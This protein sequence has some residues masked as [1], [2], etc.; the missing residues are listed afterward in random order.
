MSSTVGRVIV[1]AI[2]AE[3]VTHVFGVPGES[4]LPVLDA[5][6]DVPEVRIVPTRHEEGAGFMADAWARTT[7]R[8][9]VFMV[10]RGPGLA[11]AA[12]ALHAARQ[13]STPLVLLVGQVSRDDAGR[14]SFQ[15]L[16][17][18]AA[19][20]LLGK[21]GIEITEPD[22]AAEQ[23]QRAFYLARSGRPGPVVVSLPEDVGYA[24][25]QVTAVAR[26]TVP[27][28]AA[29]EEDLVRAVALLAG[30]GSV[31]LIVGTGGIAGAGGRAAVVALAERLG[32][33]V[34]NAWR[35]FDAFPNTHPQF[36]GNLPWLSAELVRPLRD[37]D[38]VLAIGTRL[39]DFTSMSYTVPS[40]KQKLIQIDVDAASMSVV[41]NP[42]VPIV[43]DAGSTVRRLA[44]LLESRT[45]ERRPAALAA[46][47]EAHDRYVASTAVPDDA[48]GDADLAVAIGQLR[49][50]LPA[51]AIVT[52]DAGAFAGYLNRYYRWTTPETFI[53]STS[54]PMGYAVP[55]AIGAKI[56]AP[57]RVVVGIAGDGG[58]AMTMSEIHTAVRLGLDRLVFVVFDNGVYG[59]IRN[60]QT[61]T[62]PGREIGV[63]LGSADLA[64]V[65]TGLGALGLSCRTNREFA[66]AL[67]KAIAADRPAVV[68][69]A[70]SPEQINA[71]AS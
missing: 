50:I 16:D 63:D 32:A 3:G 2:A 23:I 31:A 25:T 14:E 42:D 33:P 26:Q 37:A 38:V 59:S 71:W 66:A 20:R 21:D 13:D 6:N 52:S 53:G 1:D 8:T 57:D 55:T 34:Y 70:V 58:F 47:R 15:E 43:A 54:G 60:H 30:A 64:T 44:E 22:R 39:G 41:R 27:V 29:R 65:A 56:A 68:Q 35:R 4:Y 46:A 51:D 62:Y 28:P 9:G 49:R 18:L 10:T 67:E 19:G 40:P 17:H 61:R 69:L 24:T 36:A 12:I 48:E 45:V 11:H 7:G 5:F